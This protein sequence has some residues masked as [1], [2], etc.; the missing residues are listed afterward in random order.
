M[1]LRINP[2]VAEDLKLKRIRKDYRLQQLCLS[3]LHFYIQMREEMKEDIILELIRA[4]STITT[5][6][7]VSLSGISRSSVDAYSN[8]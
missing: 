6:T 1:K 3:I 4:D 5:V 8:L 2:I 7:M